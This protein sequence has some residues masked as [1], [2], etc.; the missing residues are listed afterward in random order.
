M[1]YGITAAFRGLRK[2]ETPLLV[3]GSL[4]ALW[5]WRRAR[6]AKKVTAHKIRLGAGE[7]IGLRVTGKRAAPKE[8]V[9]R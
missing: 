8:F 7:S 6:S 3:F 2:G 9:I 4:L 1:T 5:R